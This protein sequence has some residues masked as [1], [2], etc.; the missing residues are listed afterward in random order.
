MKGEEKMKTTYIAQLPAEA[1]NGIK[2]ELE[3]LGLNEEDINN[4]MDSRLCDLEDT[5]DIKAYLV[6]KN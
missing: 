6:L 2:R 5:I 3:E 4:A 1:Q